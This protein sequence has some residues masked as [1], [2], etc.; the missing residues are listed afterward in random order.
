M[1]TSDEKFHSWG[2]DF[3]MKKV[4]FELGWIIKP[5]AGFGLSWNPAKEKP[6]EAEESKEEDGRSLRKK[7]K[8][9]KEVLKPLPVPS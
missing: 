8:P 6:E 2:S 5:V 4:F 1:S 3:T 7:G 9:K